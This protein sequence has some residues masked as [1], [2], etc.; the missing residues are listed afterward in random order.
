M[1]PEKENVKCIPVLSFFTGGGFLDLGFETAGYRIAWTNEINPVFAKAYS[2]GM[3]STH[4]AQDKNAPEKTISSIAPIQDLRASEILQAAFPREIP[5][6][7][8]IIGGPPCID[9]SRAGKNQ[10]GRGRHGR[11]SGI[12]VETICRIRPAFFVLENVK[13]MVRTNSHR[14]YLERLQKKL[15]EN[16]YRID[17]RV[18]NA[19][20]LGV[21][22]DRERLVMIGVRHDLADQCAGRKIGKTERNWF[23][24]PSESKYHDAKSRFPWPGKER[25]GET[26]SCPKEIPYELTV[27][28]ALNG[29]TP[30]SELPNGTE[31]F[32]PYSIH[33]KQVLEGDTKRRS[34]KRL[35]RYRYSPT[36]CYGNN[37]VH[38]HP[39][40]N[41]RLSVRE[42]MRIQGIPDT[43]TLPADMHL[44]AKFRVVSNGVPVPLAHAVASSLRNFLTSSTALPKREN[45]VMIS[46]LSMQSFEI[47]IPKPAL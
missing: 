29:G 12:Y 3:T 35:H 25:R 17:S 23:P 47:P 46:K 16:G 42:A 43:Y 8:G 37:E 44:S 7:F 21:P 15:E 4:R 19:L 10:G 32:V 28:A 27:A 26:V 6:L 33:F 34:F 11:L 13:G 38:L 5:S 18:I 40:E 9:F 31:F 30:L 24:W 1:I 45:G 2:H 39:W 36:A 22:Q 14:A 41:R 20:E